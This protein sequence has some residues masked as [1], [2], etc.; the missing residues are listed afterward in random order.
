MTKDELLDA[1][2]DEREKLLE[3]IEGLSDEAMLEPGVIGEWSVKDT[4]SHLSQW[5]AELVKLLWQAQQGI[6]PTGLRY[7]QEEVDAVNAAWQAAHKDRELDSVLSDM[8]AVRKQ[9]IRRIEGFNNRDLNDAQ[10]WPWLRGEPLWKVIEVDSFGHE[11]EHA[12]QIQD[13]RAR[14][15]I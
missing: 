15:G 2:E 13:W 11:A 4:L 14:R 1:L 12:A 9:T 6:R 3:T 7:T 5:E 8:Q 10:R